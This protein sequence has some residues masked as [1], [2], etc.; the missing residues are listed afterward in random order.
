[1]G[2]TAFLAEFPHYNL[3]MVLSSHLGL[4]WEELTLQFIQADNGIQFLMT[5]KLKT[6]ICL[7]AVS[8]GHRLDGKGHSCS[9]HFCRKSLRSP[10]EFVYSFP[11]SRRSFSVFKRF[12]SSVTF[13]THFD[14]FHCLRLAAA[15][16]Y[17]HL[18][19]H[20]KETS[21]LSILY[22]TFGAQLTCS[23]SL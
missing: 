15:E 3:V 16:L 23:V 8:Q 13:I 19:S 18:W 22:W 10:T 14:E 5:V 17:L 6:S 20:F 2:S 7:L 9:P 1:M 4:L 11:S 12:N 21:I